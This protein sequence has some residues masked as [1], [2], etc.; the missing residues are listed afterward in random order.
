LS[1]RFFIIDH[2]ILYAVR[3]DPFA[4]HGDSHSS[5][6]SSS[7]V[8]SSG[9]ER[10]LGQDAVTNT[11]PPEKGENAMIFDSTPGPSSTVAPSAIE[12]IPSGTDATSPTTD[13]FALDWEP[14]PAYS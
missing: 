11:L 10:P 14:P 13:F 2:D 3:A 9:K 4:T 6:Q 12:A 7:D 1:R 8:S 5:G